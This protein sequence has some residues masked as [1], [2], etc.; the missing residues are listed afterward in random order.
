[1]HSMIYSKNNIQ[2]G[3]IGCIACIHTLH[4]TSYTYRHALILDIN[5]LHIWQLNFLLDCILEDV[6]ITQLIMHPRSNVNS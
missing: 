4:Y 6:D 3:Y 1:M 5:V 2:V